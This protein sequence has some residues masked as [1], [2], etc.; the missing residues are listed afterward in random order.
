M[1]KE[2]S[3][4]ILFF[5]ES[6]FYLLVFNGEPMPED[7]D[8]PYTLFTEVYLPTPNPVFLAAERLKSNLNEMRG[9]ATTPPP[10]ESPRTLLHIQRFGKPSTHLPMVVGLLT[11]LLILP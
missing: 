9:I 8:D 3:P 2:V 10:S 1:I 4:F 6:V 7:L 11:L 5:F